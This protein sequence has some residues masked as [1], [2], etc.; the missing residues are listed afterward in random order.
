VPKLG[1]LGSV[2]GAVG[3]GRSYRDKGLM[4][5]GPRRLRSS[6]ATRCVPICEVRPLCRGLR[7][8]YV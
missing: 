7:P 1:T 8:H 5:Q 3:N 2:R 6:K 4:L